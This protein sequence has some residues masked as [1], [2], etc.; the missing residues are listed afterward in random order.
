MVT[1]DSIYIL[2]IRTAFRDT[3]LKHS[4]QNVQLKK[5]IKKNKLFCLASK[6]NMFEII[7]TNDKSF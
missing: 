7:C 4:M 6:K 3:F 1:V 5:K 2:V